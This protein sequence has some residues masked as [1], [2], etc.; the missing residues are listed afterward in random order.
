MAEVES[1]VRRARVGRWL[2]VVVVAV[3]CLGTVYAIAVNV[4]QGSDITNV[5]NDVTKIEHTACAKFAQD[6]G[7]LKA[8]RE[9]AGLR[10]QIARSEPIK[11]PCTSFQRVTGQ[12]GRN[13]HRFYVSP[14]R[15][16]GAESLVEPDTGSVPTGASPAATEEGDAVH[17]PSQGDQP[18]SPHGGGAH[19]PGVESQPGEVPDNTEPSQPS[20]GAV[21]G[22]EGQTEPG[23]A[24]SAPAPEPTSPEPAP[25]HPIR[26]AAGGVLEEA[27]EAVNGAL[28]GVTGALHI[29]CE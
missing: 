14:V 15:R 28:C 16:G 27:G 17:Q 10:A 6:P 7:N 3:T 26:E 4:N 8:A 13:C 5:H 22:S 9:C 12:R 25:E 21:S 20:P 2:L 19:H 18:S 11:N 29:P 23:Q 24:P 1:I